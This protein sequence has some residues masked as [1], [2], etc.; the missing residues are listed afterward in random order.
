MVLFISV[1]LEIF[2]MEKFKKVKGI[3]HE[4][5]ATQSIKLFMTLLK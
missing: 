4:Y 1:Y 3:A 5:V 2:I